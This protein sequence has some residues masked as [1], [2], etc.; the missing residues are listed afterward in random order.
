MN[1]ARLC[2]IHSF[3]TEQDADE[4]HTHERTR[5]WTERRELRLSL[6][7]LPIYLGHF[8][9]SYIM[10]PKKRA[11]DAAPSVLSPPPTSCQPLTGCVLVFTSRAPASL[12]EDVI[13]AGAQITSGVSGAT[14]HV[15]VPKQFY[16]P[17]KKCGQAQDK[18]LP[19]V[20]YDW[21]Q[22]SIVSI[23]P[24]MMIANIAT[25]SEHQIQSHRDCKASSRKHPTRPPQNRDKAPSRPHPIHLQQ[26]RK[27]KHHYHPRVSEVIGACCPYLST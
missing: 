26:A 9:E 5:G 25:N 13:T 21:A 12:K 18:S 23:V 7:L 10:A 24:F 15:L 16:T 17:S 3:L 2:L 20:T 4:R 14:T 22:D 11:T 27:G 1:L 8:S 6:C 19:I